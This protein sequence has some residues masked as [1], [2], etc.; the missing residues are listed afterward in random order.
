M[1]SLVYRLAESL[2]NFTFHYFTMGHC[3][4]LCMYAHTFVCMHVHMYVVCG[5]EGGGGAPASKASCTCIFEHK[6]ISESGMN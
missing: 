4:Y 2:D 3:L 6:T 5:S 1:K